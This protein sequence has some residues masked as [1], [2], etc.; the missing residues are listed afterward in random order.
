MKE[1]SISKNIIGDLVKLKDQFAKH[2][3]KTLGEILKAIKEAD[4]ILKDPTKT[5]SASQKD[6]SKQILE[7]YS[8]FMETLDTLDTYMA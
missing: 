1:I 3:G 5:F 7:T 6:K 2:S 8:D 4:Y